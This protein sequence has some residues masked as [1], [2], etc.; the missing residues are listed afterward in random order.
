MGERLIAFSPD[1]PQGRLV[2]TWCRENG[3]KPKAQIEV[4]SGQV[5]CA[6]AACGAGV[7]V[8]DALTARARNHDRLGFRPLRGGPTYEVSVVRHANLPQSALSLAFQACVKEAFKALRR[9][10]GRG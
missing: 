10:A 4:R 9:R 6:L 2:A 7:A 1:T 5:A 3:L 8:V